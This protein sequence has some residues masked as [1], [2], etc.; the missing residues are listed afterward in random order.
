[1]KI[2]L[3]LAAD[4]FVALIIATYTYFTNEVDAAISAG[5]SILTAF[6]PICLISAAPLVLRNA[7]AI[8]EKDGVKVNHLKALAMIP[9]VD[10]VAVPLNRFLMNGDY[11][12]TDLVPV[13]LSQPALLGVAATAEQK[14]EHSLGKIIYKTAAGRGLKL[15]NVAASNEFPGLGIEV[16]SNGSTIRVGNPA[17]VEQQGVSVNNSLLTKI[18]KLSVYGK[19]VLMVGI[20]RMARGIIALKDE[21]DADAKEFLMLLKRKKMITVLL[22]AA[23]KKTV[24]GL[25]KNFN[26]DAVKTNL[27]PED[28]A[29]ELQILRAQGH[30]VA[31]I[32]NEDRDAP[33]VEVAD[34]SILLQEKNL[35]P[36]I[37]EDEKT[38][39]RAEN[40][41]ANL[42]AELEKIKLD[43]E[44]E[45]PKKTVPETS[46]EK[47]KESA[48]IKKVVNIE[49]KVDIE[50]PTLKKFLKVRKIAVRAADLIHTNQKIAYL[51]WIILVPL[52]LMNTLQD[53]PVKLGPIEILC[54]VAV[55]LLMIIFNSI[56][57]KSRSDD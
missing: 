50:I 22:T 46:P 4:F 52:A 3:F 15:H 51:S 26:L 2:K 36:L 21:V 34:V 44:D 23:S 31:F 42:K 13:G 19:T 27:L 55:F 7:R 20:G 14:A 38:D 16:M 49:E 39:E 45:P 9:E 57:M 43:D 17:W 28:K 24:K 8:L 30:T 25:V 18:D 32:T 1:M 37:V 10:T 54:G 40:N 35:S 33:A 11:F 56:R 12:V 47:D 48:Q 41:L 6:S 53:P 29:R 5:L